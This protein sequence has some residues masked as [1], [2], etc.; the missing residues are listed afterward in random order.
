[1]KISTTVSLD[2]EL[3]EGARAFARSERRS[4]SAQIETWI[5]EKLSGD[6]PAPV[7]GRAEVPHHL[8]PDPEADLAKRTVVRVSD[9]PLT[10]G[11]KQ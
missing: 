9:Q 11:T 4:L 5:E 6:E 2:G 10:K 7:E 8:T 1:M 3:L